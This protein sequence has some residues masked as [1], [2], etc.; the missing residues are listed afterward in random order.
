[1][2]NSFHGINCPLENPVEDL[3]SHQNFFVYMIEGRKGWYARDE[4]VLLSAGLTAFVR[5]G[6]TLL[7]QYLD[8]PSCVV[9]FF[10]SDDFICETLRSIGRDRLSEPRAVPNVVRIHTGLVLQGF[11]QGMLAHFQEARPTPELLRLKFRELLLS[12]VNDARNTDALA[13][14]CSLLNDPAKE[15]VRR[16][17]EDNYHF[18]LEL[19]DLARLS[20]RSLTAFKRDVQELFGMAP[21]RWIRQRRLERARALLASGEMQVSEV[22]FRC[23]FENLSHFSRT[24]KEEFGQPPVAV[25]RAVGA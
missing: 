5:K 24:F 18:N 13:Y 7:R 12:V 1:M 9:L 19:S 17:M 10:V 22:A 21:G 4:E 2:T 23:G 25:R 3:W 15:R 16:V 11:F 14:F 6:A 20:G 8:Q